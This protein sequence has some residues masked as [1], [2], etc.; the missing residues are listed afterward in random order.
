ME[1]A[2]SSIIRNEIGEISIHFKGPEEIR[3]IF[4]TMNVNFRWNP[5]ILKENKTSYTIE[6]ENTEN[7]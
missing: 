7:F 1:K 4:M 6:Q 3:N 5:Q 2:Q